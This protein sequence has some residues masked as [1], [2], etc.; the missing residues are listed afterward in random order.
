MRG[1]QAAG[2]DAFGDQLRLLELEAPG[3]PAPDEVVIS[4]HAPGKDDM[5]RDPLRLR[6]G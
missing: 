2:I 1:M 5:C 4:V 3:F 6:H